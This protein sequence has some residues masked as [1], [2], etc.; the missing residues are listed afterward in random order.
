MPP[1]DPQPAAP[2]APEPQ[3]SEPAPSESPL[4]PP[5]EAPPPKPDA[6]ATYPDS[7]PELLLNR[8]TAEIA[9]LLGTP[10]TIEDQAPALIWIYESKGIC[11]LRLFFYPQLEG[12]RFLSLTYEI[13]P[14]PD[15]NAEQ[16]CI[17][18][19]RRAHVG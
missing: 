16:L 17:A 2:P 8:D 1:E 11:T 7:D 10:L 9:D 13:T 12:E 19:L 18:T 6:L 3:V 14:A 15:R 5:P 4:P